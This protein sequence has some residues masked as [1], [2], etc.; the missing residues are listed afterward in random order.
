MR[1]A[2]FML[3]LVL[4]LA[5]CS[6]DDAAPED[7][8]VRPFSEIQASE[9]SFESDSLDPGRGI[10]RVTTTEPAICSITWGETEA[11][12]NQ[13]NSLSMNGTGIIQHDV[14]LPGAMPGETYYF[15]LQGSTADGQ[16]FQSELGTFT[17]PE[18]EAPV[19]GGSVDHGENLALGASVVEVS[20]EFSASFAASRALD[21]DL[22]TEWSTRGD[23]DDGFVVI[24]LG[25]VMNIGGVAF[26]TRSMADGS[27]ITDQFTVSVDGGERLGPF[28][29]GTSADHGFVALGANGRVLR[30]DIA[31]STGG[32]TGAV[33]IQVFGPQV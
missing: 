21:G 16:L 26:V 27:A 9:L 17:L 11:M 25:S 12:G 4:V 31:S 18:P 19:G 10:F 30:F 5:A 28:R 15:R 1:K 14:I 7:G 22:S 13:N 20:S 2:T 8:L 23:G 3:G 6:G 24:D 32:N 29:A 33:E